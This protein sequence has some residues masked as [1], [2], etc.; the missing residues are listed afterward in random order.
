MPADPSLDD[1]GDIEDIVSSSD[2][3]VGD[4]VGNKSSVVPR[5]RRSR[6][7]GRY[8][9]NETVVCEE[10]QGDSYIPGTL[11]ALLFFFSKLCP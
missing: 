6:Q 8:H 1:V 3:G 4:R 11:S 10:A 5:A 9:S 2:V 7:Q